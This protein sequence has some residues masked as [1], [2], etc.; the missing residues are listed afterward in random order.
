MDN[1]FNINQWQSPKGRVGGLPSETCGFPRF[2]RW[3]YYQILNM[4]TLTRL[5]VL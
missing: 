1:M 4:A 2:Y 3:P 5:G